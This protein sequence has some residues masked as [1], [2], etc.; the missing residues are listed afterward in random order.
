MDVRSRPGLK[1]VNS[2]FG[3]SGDW[4]FILTVMAAY[5]DEDLLCA[6]LAKFLGQK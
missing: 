1:M 4:A 2:D 3:P 5:S 6:K